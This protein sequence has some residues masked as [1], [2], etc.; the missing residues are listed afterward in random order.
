MY[1]SIHFPLLVFLTA[2]LCSPTCLASP[3]PLL[4]LRH[5]G[6]LDF[7]NVQ[8]HPLP[9]IGHGV[10]DV[11]PAIS[12][13]T[14]AAITQAQQI[15]TEY[16]SIVNGIAIP[17]GLI[18]SFFGYFLLSP[19]LFLSAF[20]TG[21]SVSFISVSALLNDLTP[22]SAVPSAGQVIHIDELFVRSPTNAWI[23][24]FA[25]LFGGSLFGFI[26]IRALSLGMF[27]I[28]A[29]LG[30]IVA[31]SLRTSVLPKL[32][33]EQ[34]RTAFI[35]TAVTLGLLLGCLTLLFQKQML[36]FST[37]FT[38]AFLFVFGIGYFAGHFPSVADIQIGHF[39]P[40]WW[41]L[42]YLACALL[43]GILGMLFQFWLATDKRLPDHYSPYDPSTARPGRRYR[44][45]RRFRDVRH[46]YQ[47]PS[48]YWDEDYDEVYD[49]RYDEEMA[50]RPARRN[51]S[52][53]ATNNTNAANYYQQ[54]PQQ[55]Q[56]PQQALPSAPPPGH[57]QYQNGY[58]NTHNEQR[59]LPPPQTAPQSH[60]RQAAPPA[61]PTKQE[62]SG[63]RLFNPFSSSNDASD[64][65]TTNQPRESFDELAM[66]GS[67]EGEDA[68]QK[69]LQKQNS[70]SSTAAPQGSDMSSRRRGSRRTNVI[71]SP[72]EDEG[73]G[74][75]AQQFK[76]SNAGALSP[77]PLVDVPLNHN[78]EK[79]MDKLN[80]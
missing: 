33:P 27:S 35:A 74:E 2:A 48:P 73:D 29:A 79:Q 55:Q 8:E 45:A 47:Q 20:I 1:A 72:D 50:E 37:A 57:G 21:G 12:N 15:L 62:A 41:V 77:A 16:T 58:A 60:T 51:R 13:A 5:A 52:G 76:S 43:I 42:L 66:M 6:P 67:Y 68:A 19:V 40:D 39:E 63:W 56:Q 14:Q 24:I 3:E 70:R 61:Q 7:G 65:S 10:D 46:R 17:I 64:K 53:A 28:G 32:F 22:P 9:K 69:E 80:I 18:I 49:E 71:E 25:M 23:C 78:D 59:Q 75:Q 11:G 38:G 31:V 36:I 44:F 34:P 54:Y 4:D 26:A 30:V